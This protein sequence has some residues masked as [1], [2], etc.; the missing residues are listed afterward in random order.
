PPHYKSLPL[1]QSRLCGMLE[2]RYS[3]GRDGH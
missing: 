3:L 1:R 2:K